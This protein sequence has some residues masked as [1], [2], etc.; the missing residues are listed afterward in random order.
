MPKRRRNIIHNLKRLFSTDVVVRNIG[1][2]NLKILDID[3][4]QKHKKISTDTNT[5][6]SGLYSTSQTSLYGA[7][8]NRNIQ[9]IRPQLYSEYDVMN[10][11]AIIASALDIMSDESTLRNDMG[12]I[13]Q[14]KSSND[15]IQKT[16]YNLFYDILNIEFNLW[17]WTRQMCKYGDFFLKLELAEDFGV[18]NCIPHNAYHIE[19]EDAY[20]DKNPHSTRYIF[21]PEGFHVGSSGYYNI[22]NVTDSDSN[23]FTTFDNYEVAHF[24]LMSDPNFLPYGVSVL[25]PARKLYKQY[26]MLEDSMLIHRIVRAADKRVYYINVGTIPP[27]EVDNFMQKTIDKMKKVP[28]IDSETGDYNLR[29]NLEN[30]LEDIYIPVRGND[31]STKV[32]TLGGLNWDGIKDVEYLR[33]KLF[34]ALK[35]P[36]AFMGYTENLEGKC[37]DPKTL[38][39]LIDGRTLTVRELIKEYEEGAKNYVYS[40]DIETNDIVPGEIDWVGF[41]RKNAQIVKVWLDNEKYIRCTPDHMFLTRDGGWKEAQDLIEGE[42]LMSLYLEWKEKYSPKNHKVLKIEW[43]DDKIDTC[44]L[45]IKKYHNFGTDAGVIIHNSTLAAMDIRF[46]RTID[47]IQRTILSELNKIALVH[48]YILGFEEEN[49]VNFE[50]SLT[51][52]S[53]IYEQEK[54]ELLKAKTE[55]TRD[56]LDLKLFP[57]S[58][59]YDN[60]YNLSQ[61]E[62]EEFRDLL[63]YDSWRGFRLKQILEEGNDPK[64]TGE[65]YGTP[66]DLAILY[67]KDRYTKG[68]GVPE[69]YDEN[70]PLGRPKEKSSNIGTQQS[71]FGKD[72]LGVKRMKDTD[73]NDSDDV[74]PKYKGGSPLALEYTDAKKTYMKNKKFLKNLPRTKKS[75]IVMGESSNL[76]NEKNIK[77]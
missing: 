69:G 72:R 17:S 59:I 68:K 3:R 62:Y 42:S 19:R 43:L 12:E 50:L 25:E 61:E 34:A 10:S 16:L 30:L 51:P 22:P 74:R 58:W 46:A 41:T 75:K 54:V 36:P 13:L 52:P 45:T 73:K 18:Y 57:E 6:H 8:L 44:D 66:H 11:D 70:K 40:L 4:T 24:R 67:G 5:T 35:I 48:L 38:I 1:G 39:P 64:E 32:D 71:N 15:K 56:M 76:L 31:S 53:I 55:L 37:I 20:D 2:T 29:Y 7:Q 47:R 60:I 21:N 27:D 65:S 26:T 14:I 23:K 28:H 77:E 33:E 9:I 49:L 63:I